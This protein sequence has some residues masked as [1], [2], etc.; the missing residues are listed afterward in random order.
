MAFLRYTLLLLLQHDIR[1][2]PA[3]RPS[4]K[5][6]TGGG[7]KGKITAVIVTPAAGLA[8][9]DT[10]PLAFGSSTTGGTVP[11]CST[12]STAPDPAATAA[13]LHIGGCKCLHTSHSATAA[14][15]TRY[16]GTALA[17]PCS[18]PLPPSPADSSTP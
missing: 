18:P 16:P 5:L 11:R 9:P 2:P 17:H 15:R 13:L 6:R 1:L 14:P 4:P 8:L 12:G 7:G 10:P 3:V